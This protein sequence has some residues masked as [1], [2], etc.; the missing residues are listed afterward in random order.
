MERQ[1][2]VKCKSHD[3][4]I[5]KMKLSEDGFKWSYG[6][7]IRLNMAYRYGWKK[8]TEGWL[9]PKCIEAIENLE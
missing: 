7:Y 9:C 6:T 3:R 2:Y 1:R 4:H 8:T 5:A